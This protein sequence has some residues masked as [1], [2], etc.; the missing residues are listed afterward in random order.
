MDRFKKTLSILLCL[1]EPSWATWSLVQSKFTNAPGSGTCAVTTAS[2]GAG[3][4]LV[5]TAGMTTTGATIS[6][7]TNGCA[8]TWTHCTNCAGSDAATLSSDIYYCLN[9]ASGVT[10]IT[11][12]SATTMTQCSIYEFS[13]TNGPALYDTSNNRDHTPSTSSFPGVSLTLNGSNDVIV[14][15]DECSGSIS[16]VSGNGFAENPGFSSIG[17]NGIAFSSNT[18]S[19][20]APTWTSGGSTDAQSALAIKETSTASG[21]VSPFCGFLGD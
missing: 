7:M 2:T 17:A 16:A 14:Q 5:A 10:S 6:S 9:S 15:A 11:V 13:T 18:T 1:T 21:C 8:G 19:G 4:V 12:N 3:N 20:G